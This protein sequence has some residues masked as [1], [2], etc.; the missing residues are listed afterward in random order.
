MR[1]ISDQLEQDARSFLVVIAVLRA[2]GRR[3]DGHAYVR[4]MRTLPGLRLHG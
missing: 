2:R 1:V 4:Q 3:I